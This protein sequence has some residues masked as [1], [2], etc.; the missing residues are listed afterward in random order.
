MKRG[1]V[2][3][4]LLLAAVAAWF[5]WSQRT[6]TAEPAAAVRDRIALRTPSF[7]LVLNPLKMSDV[8]SRQVATLIHAGL[9][10]QTDSGETVPM[11]ARSWRREGNKTTFELKPDVSF[12]NG[13]P[14]RAEDVVR[15]LCNAMQPSAPMAWA[16][17]RVVRRPSADGKSVECT[18]VS[19]IGDLQVAIEETEPAASLFD[20]LSGPAGWILPG[21]DVPEAPYGVLPGIG[22]YKVREIVPDSKV[23]LE[24]RPQG[25]VEPARLR[26]VEFLHLPDDTAAAERFATR[27]LDVLD[28]N[29]PRLVQLLLP[30]LA[31]GELKYPGRVA[32]R[33]WERYR[34]VIVNPGALAKKGFTTS[35]QVGFTRAYSA[36]VDR[37][38]L[39]TLA[40]GTADAFASAFPPSPDSSN[41]IED[42]AAT[43]PAT[44]LAMLTEGDAYSDAIAAALPRNVGTVAIDYKGVDKGVLL[45]SVFTGDFDLVSMLIEAPVKTNALWKSF[46]S[47]GNPYV[48]LG[49]PIPEMSA[50][51]VTS[52]EGVRRAGELVAQRGNWVL[53]LK[54]RRLQATSPGVE[55]VRFTPSGQTHLSGIGIAN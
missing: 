34:L 54:E 32:S 25:G 50:L 14:A 10:L 30:N 15:S 26:F 5:I 19:A 39:A 38:R 35:Q 22:P 23:V 4:A 6:P 18:G 47:P 52:P 45:N 41:A 2:V 37:A 9:V 51:D 44:N 1:P 7:A 53:L 21:P 55:G 46:F 24:A 31:T 17:E 27:A 16:F 3:A 20:A 33:P 36:A 40:G 48:A 11:L 12:S 8:E 42:G 13:T 43:F 28:I 49:T 29:S